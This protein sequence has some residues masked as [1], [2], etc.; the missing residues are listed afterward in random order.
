MRGSKQTIVEIY[1]EIAPFLGVGITFALTI[2]LFLYIGMLLD[3]RWLS[4]PWMKLIGAFLGISVG[5][6]HF[7]KVVSG[8]SRK[9]SNQ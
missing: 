5:F 8:T 3:D 6:Y 4:D 9:K 2:I 1:R 7:F